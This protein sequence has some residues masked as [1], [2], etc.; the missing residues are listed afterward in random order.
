MGEIVDATVLEWQPVRSDVATGVFG[1][2]LLANGLKVVLTRVAPGG[3]FSVHRDDYGHLFYFLSGQ[4]LVSV[5]GKEF[6]IR[7]GLAVK[8][9]EGEDHAY[10]NTGTEE[11]MLIS[12]NI[13]GERRI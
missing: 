2:T 7:P 12:V 8:V 4:G 5:G 3:R 11:L 1:K 9:M 6:E 10:E 13:S